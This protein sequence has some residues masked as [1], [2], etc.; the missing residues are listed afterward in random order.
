MTIKNLYFDH[1]TKSLFVKRTGEKPFKFIMSERNCDDIEAMFEIGVLAL[2]ERM[3]FSN[4]TKEI[5]I[6][7]WGEEND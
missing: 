4:V 6:T 5:N 2:E 1:K 3:K 7:N